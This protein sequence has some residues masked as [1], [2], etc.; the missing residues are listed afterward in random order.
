LL[1]KVKTGLFH[2][3]SHVSSQPKELIERMLTVEPSL[4]IT[5]PEV[6]LHPW[7][8]SKDPTRGAVAIP[9][10]SPFESTAIEEGFPES[11]EFELDLLEALT[12]LGW[13]NRPALTAALRAKKYS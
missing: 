13:T 6:M 3:P 2:I 9:T 11:Y 8:L 7:Y 12:F 1:N 4:R 10:L 5:L